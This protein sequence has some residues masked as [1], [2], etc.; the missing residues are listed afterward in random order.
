M[1]FGRPALSREHVGVDGLLDRSSRKR[2]PLRTVPRRSTP[3]GQ[4][5][6]TKLTGSF[7]SAA[8]GGVQTNWV[9]AM[10][11]GKRNFCVP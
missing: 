6:P 7:V 3:K 4:V 9:I 10:P 11:P 8:R 2:H 1:G 5:L